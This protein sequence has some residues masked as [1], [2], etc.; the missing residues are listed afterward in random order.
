MATLASPGVSVSVIDESFYGS[1]GAGTVPLIIVATG[2]NKAHVSG[3]GTASGTTATN[4]TAPQLVTSQRELIQTFG[5]PY[6]KSVSGTAQH[7]YETNEY[8]LLAAYSYLGSANRAYVVRADVNTTELEPSAT[9]P[10]GAPANGALW[11]DTANSTF[12]VFRYNATTGVWDKKTVTTPVSTDMDGVDKDKPA[13]AFGSNGDY[14]VSTEDADGFALGTTA[15]SIKFWQKVGGTWVQIN[16]AGKNSLSPTA[17]TVTVGGT[18]AQPSSPAG[19]D[20]WIKT[21]SAGSGTNFVIKEYNS[22]TSAF[23]TKTV[24]P[25]ADDNEA[26]QPGN[27][28][29]GRKADII[30]SALNSGELHHSVGGANSASFTILDGGSGYDPDNP[31]TVTIATTEGGTAAAP[32]AQPTAV[33]DSTGAIVAIVTA[34]ND[35]AGLGANLSDISAVSITLNGGAK[36]AEGSL[37]TVPDTTAGSF[38][39][40]RFPGASGTS[41]TVAKQTDTTNYFAADNELEASA[42][43]IVGSPTTGTYWYD[44]RLLATS[45]DIYKKGNGGWQSVTNATGA[46]GGLG[47]TLT[48]GTTAPTSGAQTGHLWIDTNFLETFTIKEYNAAG[49]WVARDSSDQSTSNGVVFADLTA[50]AGDNT[51][52]LSGSNNKGATRIANAPNPALYPDGIICVNMIHSSYHV[53]QYDS[54]LTTTTKWRSAAG[55]KA[56]GSAYIGRK[57]QRRVVVKALQAALTTNTAIREDSL[58]YTLIATPG[59]PE[60]ADEMLS[61]NVDRKETAFVI[62]DSPFR[63]APTDVTAWQAGTNGTENG[64]DALITSGSQCATYYPSG[65]ATNTDGTSVVVPASHMVLRT[66]SYS[67]GIAYPW[68][69]PAGLTRGLI[70]NATNVGYIDSEG[71]F[72]ALALNEG[73]RDTLYGA[74]VNPITNFPGQ[75]LFIYGQKTLSATSS[76]LDRINVARLIAYMRERLDPLARPFAFEP[77]DESTRANAQETVSRFLADIMAKRGIFDFAV[78]CDATNNTAA[79][80]D[81]NELYIDI[82]IEPAKAAEFIYIPIRIVNTGTL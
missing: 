41:A 63:L 6:F 73:Q 29:S 66:I 14:A 77:N 71:E 24:K 5:T 59:Y 72:T 62:I 76:A 47:L 35:A 79:R 34:S 49:K 30:I 28:D 50:T 10:T 16:D 2:T 33:V 54:T 82:A 80:I 81:K 68:F 13:D 58:N 51:T 70:S 23:T 44:S 11:L 15:E 65:L 56:D 21:E 61:L 38:L 75:G 69:A 31:P 22:T 52:T 4:A 19:N 9:E 46:D 42:T 32:T 26:A 27:F 60:C 55:N 64:E 18:A 43:A 12:G 20:V 40:K 57:S 74:K 45:F 36:P 3:T 78:V 7:G 67:D 17:N 53:K 48:V 37:Y 39:F 8:G 1:A 25:Y